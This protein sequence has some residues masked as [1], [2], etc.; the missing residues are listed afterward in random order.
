[1]MLIRKLNGHK[2]QLKAETPLEAQ[3]W[4]VLNK[5]FLKGKMREKHL[6]LQYTDLSV[7]REIFIPYKVLGE[8]TPV[9]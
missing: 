4:E 9:S 5:G 7:I 6:S 8:L 1:M 3:C 2:D